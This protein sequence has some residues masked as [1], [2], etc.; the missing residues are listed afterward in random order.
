MQLIE[1]SHTTA[2]TVT[3]S[4]GYVANVSGTCGG[5]LVG[6]TYTTNAITANCS[7]NATFLQ[8]ING[9]CGAA[10]VNPTAFAPTAGLCDQ[11]TA[12]GVSVGAPWTWTCTG[13]NGG[14]TASCSVPNQSTS[15]GTGQGRAV[16]SGGTWVVDGNNSAGFIPVSGHPKSPAAPPPF[17]AFPHGLFDFTLIAGA[18][19]TSAT[20]TITYPQALPP[21]FLY[22]KYGPTPAGYG[23]SG[24]DCAQPHWYVFP[25][26]VLT[27]PNEITLTIMDGG[28]GDDDLTA[29]SVIVDQGGP[30]IYAGSDQPVPVFGPWAL[31]S[32]MG[33]L[34]ALGAAMLRRRAA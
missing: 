17:I 16:V 3:P 27:A 6:S 4:A 21:N 30:G 24:A 19:G 5:A 34:A 22:Y 33:A 9:V 20:I 10:A 11:G 7:V 28:V 25:N 31:W 18:A 1:Y 14:T 15:T 8:V 29:N 32:L 26:A 23:C 2:F 12:S 13:A